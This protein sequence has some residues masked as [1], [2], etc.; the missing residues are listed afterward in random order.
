[1]LKFKHPQTPAEADERFQLI[2]DRGD[3]LL[4]EFVCDMRVR[5]TLV[6]LTNEM[7]EAEPCEC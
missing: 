2:E 4:V 6:Y 3:R 7:T 1:M 5:P